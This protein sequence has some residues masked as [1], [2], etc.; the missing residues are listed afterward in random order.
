MGRE[1]EIKFS[2]SNHQL[3][4]IAAQW[5]GWSELAMETT[6]FDTE[7]STLS[8]KKYTLR[9][10]MENG[11]CV[12]TLKT[13][14]PGFGRGEWSLQAPWCAETVAALFEAAQVAPV[15]FEKLQAVCG[16]RFTRRAKILELPHCTVEI[17]LDKGFLTGGD[18]EI[19]LCEVEV[20]VKSGSEEAA[21][22]WANTL[23]NQYQLQL[24]HK[25]KFRRAL[26]LAKG[27]MYG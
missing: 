20:E 16:A 13:P 24:Q 27:V 21:V 14:A 6:Y 2:A 5:S 17:A 26:D 23:A 11:S 3:E 25:S 1:F 4:S 10:R 19:P 22:E 9:R 12:C 7:S 8:S 15:A 18:K